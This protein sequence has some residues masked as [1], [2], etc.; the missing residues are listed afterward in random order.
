MMMLRVLGVLAVLVLVPACSGINVQTEI[1]DTLQEARAAGA[2][3][4]GWIPRGLPES[5]SD[6][7]AAH[8]ED[9]R[10]WGAFTFKPSDDAALKALLGDEITSGSVECDAPGRLEWWPRVLRSPIDLARVRAT[11]FRVY[12]GRDGTLTVVVNW[13]QGRAHYWMG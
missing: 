1:Y 8:L 3:E 10:R 6:L 9:G 12:R 2:V 13:T 7:R 5:A 11:G 4:R